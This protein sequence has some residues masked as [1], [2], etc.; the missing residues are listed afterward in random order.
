MNAIL[1]TLLKIGIQ[2]G[3]LSEQLGRMLDVIST[4]PCLPL[5]GPVAFFLWDETRKCLVLSASKKL[6]KAHRSACQTVT[7]KICT[8]MQALQTGQIQIV[9]PESPVS[10]VCTQMT[11]K[12]HLA[13]PI[14]SKSKDHGVLLLALKQAI[15]PD[16]EELKFFQTLSDT[17]GDII[18]ARQ[19]QKSLQDNEIRLQTILSTAVD[20]IISVDEDGLVQSLN[21]AAAR[22]FGYQPNQIIGQNINR[23]M[24][25]PFHS[26]HDGYIQTYLKT[27]IAR[28]IGMGREIQCALRRDG[29]VFPAYLAVSEVPVK[30]KRLF[31]A[32]VR[33][34][35]QQKQ[36]EQQIQEARD[37]ALESSRLKSEFLANM[38]HEI[39]TPMNGV[40]GMTEL[41][42]DS[43][44][45]DVQKDYALTIQGSANS[46]L[47]II[48]DILDFSKIEAGKLTMEHVEFDLMTVLEDA[49]DLFSKAAR[50][51]QIEI[52]LLKDSNI[53]SPVIGDP[54]RLR[55]ILT[56]LVGNA[57]KFTEKGDVLIRVQ[58]MIQTDE[59]Q[60]L[61]FSVSDTGMGIAPEKQRLLFQSFT[62]V[63]GAT[64]RRYGGTGLGLAISRRL[65]EMMGGEIGME[66]TPGKGSTFWFTLPL[67]K[68]TEC[69][70]SA[71]ADS[72]LN[73][74]SPLATTRCLIVDANA[75]S[76]KIL[77]HYLSN[78]NVAHETA[79][80]CQTAI[81]MLETAAL[82]NSPFTLLLME[83]AM[84]EMDGLMLA[85]TIDENPEIP[86]PRMILLSSMGGH[87]DAAALQKAGLDGFLTKPVRQSKLLD[88]LFTVMG[89]ESAK[90]AST[91]DS[92]LMK[93]S[94]S[95]SDVLSGSSGQTPP[96]RILLVEDNPVSQKMAYITL[97]KLGFDVD[98][99][100]NGR[101]GV[102]KLME[103]LY[104]LVLM[105]IQMPEMDGFE[106]TR[107]IRSLE[108]DLCHTPVVAMT[109]H[110]MAGD[111]EKCIEAGMDD[112]I[113]KPIN[114]DV[115]VQILNKWLSKP[116][117]D[118]D[119]L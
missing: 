13:I 37:A 29:T 47:T 50:K 30:G 94:K 70:L 38:S 36:Y 76:R 23:L 57:V 89:G 110:A 61:R 18:K 63:D 96:H 6:S 82:E 67:T 83:L 7:S 65:V 51:R 72:Q 14:H 102:S 114:R 8:C 35:T 21:P 1:N 115:L 119:K 97:S 54:V 68:Q 58:M 55:Q 113:S 109:A 39:R 98:L 31:T 4:I 77:H 107:R 32:I 116:K 71:I 5:A 90:V 19:I 84:P 27:G 75:T 20:G 28:I 78:W 11:G 118:S 106:A 26:Q 3:E 59:T 85:Q 33:D 87:V 44:L 56:N 17:L 86:N 69:Y 10:D 60:K 92:Y 12:P 73:A 91:A 81:R 48:N 117:D 79:G 111:R 95:R 42:L 93:K 46:L 2:N 88:T 45:T 34:L 22:I 52:G 112:Y 25:E 74:I 66:S 100:E 53:V 43:G 40:I 99:A 15:Q 41:L 24:I 108:G 101:Q 80:D 105:D 64:T 62:Q 103:N 49:I 9:Q 16:T 104:D